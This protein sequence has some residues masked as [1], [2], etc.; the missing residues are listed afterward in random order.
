M[1]SISSN[2]TS[3]D[4]Y[5]V[6]DGYAARPQIPS[7]ELTRQANNLSRSPANVHRKLSPDRDTPAFSEAA[8]EA[9][10]R[11]KR[12]SIKAHAITTSISRGDTPTAR[13]S[14]PIASQNPIMVPRGSPR[15]PPISLPVDTDEPQSSSPEAPY[16]G[17]GRLI[18]QWQKK[19]KSA[20]ADQSRPVPPGKR[21]GLPH[22]RVGTIHVE[23]R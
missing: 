18:D 10:P 17:V 22:K 7:K 14:K 9:T 8:N 11:A 15:K 23:D 20:E 16:Q 5:S 2:A 3:S 1:K 13:L 6:S 4:A 21:G 19:S 12:P